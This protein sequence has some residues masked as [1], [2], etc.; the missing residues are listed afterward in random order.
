MIN[1][2]ENDSFLV[3][4]SPDRPFWNILSLILL[5]FWRKTWITRKKGQT[6][7]TTDKGQVCFYETDMIKANKLSFTKCAFLWSN[8]VGFLILIGI[9]KFAYAT[10]HG[11]KE[12]I[13]TTWNLFVQQFFQSKN[14]WTTLYVIFFLSNIFCTNRTQKIVCVHLLAHAYYT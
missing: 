1:F 12:S 11:R 7:K 3:F 10:I 9:L 6:E 2:Q 4:L 5:L 13:G 8:R 14:T